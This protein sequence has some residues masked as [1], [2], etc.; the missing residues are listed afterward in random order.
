MENVAA[1]YITAEG[2]AGRTNWSLTQLFVG[3]IAFSVCLVFGF[4]LLVREPADTGLLDVF[5]KPLNSW[6]PIFRDLPKRQA[7]CFSGISGLV[8]AFMS[9]LV[10]GGIPYN[11]LFD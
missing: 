11:R 9:L 10:I 7:L 2:S 6:I 8:A 5:L 3:W 1:V 4:I